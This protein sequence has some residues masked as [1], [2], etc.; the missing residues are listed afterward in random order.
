MKNKKEKN[1]INGLIIYNNN[2]YEL[3]LPLFYNDFI[4][5]CINELK[6]DII[7]NSIN[8][9]YNN[10]LVLINS[11]KDYENMINLL[12]SNKINKINILIST[13]NNF[14]EDLEIKR[15]N[16]SKLNE[17]FC[18]I[19]NNYNEKYLFF[20][21]SQITKYFK[22]L[23][24]K[25]L[26]SNLNQNSENK[27]S[28]LNEILLSQIQIF[29]KGINKL[30]DI[31]K[32]KLSQINIDDFKY[33]NFHSKINNNESIIYCSTI[34]NNIKCE[35][36]LIIPIVGVRFKCCIC[37]NYNLCVNCEEKNSYL[38]FHEH[39]NF[40]L[41]REELRNK[42]DKYF[43][44][45]KCLNNKLNFDFNLKEN[46]NEFI[47]KNIIIKNDYNLPW[48]G[49][50]ETQLKCNRMIST[51]FCENIYLP[52]LS[53]NESSSIDIIFKNINE[54]PKGNYKSILNFI[55]NKKIY[56]RPLIININL[57]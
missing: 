47:I 55:V 5:Y 46:K 53:N 14:E 21:I 34:H 22:Y 49:Y 48:L 19:F 26:I 7:M 40:I 33:C 38:H 52:P 9:N 56:G 42:N 29:N 31:E 24:L 37:E 35:N 2:K 4:S 45:Y 17:S 23:I 15:K 57:I 30:K 6:I 8:Y 20:F 50:K 18:A 44:S 3:D 27:I 36:C 10:H 39:N 32:N 28:S 41:I 13:K 25:K 1:K 11:S 12:I 51:I 54:M 16:S 43:Y